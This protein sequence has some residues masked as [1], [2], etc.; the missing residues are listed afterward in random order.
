MRPLLERRG[1]P[2]GLCCHPYDLCTALIA[3]EAGVILT[4][5]WGAPLQVPLEVEADVAWVGYA[6]AAIR[7]SVAPLLAAALERRGLARAAL[8]PRPE[9]GA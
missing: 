6:N 8:S 2:G 1:Q 4:D 5:P 7:E 3:E 9:S